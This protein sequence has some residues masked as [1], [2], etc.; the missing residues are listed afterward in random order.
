MGCNDAGRKWDLF[1]AH[2]H[3]LAPVLFLC[4]RT[5]LDNWWRWYPS[6]V[7]SIDCHF[8]TFARP[9][10]FLLCN[11]SD[12]HDPQMENLRLQQIAAMQSAMIDSM[13]QERH[14][15]I[16]FWV[17]CSSDSSGLKTNI[18]LSRGLWQLSDRWIVEAYQSEEEGKLLLRMTKTYAS[19]PP[20]TFSRLQEMA[21]KGEDHRT[22]SDK[23]LSHGVVAAVSICWQPQ[24]SFL[25]FLFLY[26]SFLTF[27][28]SL[29]TLLLVG[30]CKAGSIWSFEGSLYI[31]IYLGVHSRC[32]PV[33]LFSTPIHWYDHDCRT[34]D[35]YINCNSALFIPW[36]LLT[37]RNIR[38]PH[39]FYLSRLRWDASPTYHKS[40][41]GAPNKEGKRWGSAKPPDAQET[42]AVG[43]QDGRN[44]G[45]P[46]KNGVDHWFTSGKYDGNLIFRSIFW[47][48]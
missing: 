14:Q 41:L 16:C 22:N 28:W 47:N 9:C 23:S 21:K 31:W 36:L 10:P 29:H 17:Q 7:M 6:Q 8:V 26:I 20:D 11:A 30:K 3:G 32:F 13:S 2:F 35:G 42:G 4:S 15:R 39:Q 25:V 24:A 38:S 37:V 19:R 40:F 27:F 5:L 44:Q 12:L 33:H 46:P 34:N 18:W 45:R 1:T 48:G 43:A